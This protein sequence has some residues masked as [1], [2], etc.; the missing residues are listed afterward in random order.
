MWPKYPTYL[1]FSICNITILILQG[2][3][4]LYS[5]PIFAVSLL[6]FWIIISLSLQNLRDPIPLGQM[7]K[8]HYEQ[9]YWCWLW[10]T[11]LQNQIIVQTLINNFK[12][13]YYDWKNVFEANIKVLFFTKR[14]AYASDKLKQTYLLICMNLGLSISFLQIS[15]TVAPQVF[16]ISHGQLVVA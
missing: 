14:F 6:L 13:I 1:L 11:I 2:V 12:L 5:L 4:W 8:F 10:V 15:N 3:L 7:G 16:G 9:L